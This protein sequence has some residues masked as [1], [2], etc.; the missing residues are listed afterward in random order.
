MT[1]GRSLLF[2]AASGA[3]LLAGVSG[4]TAGAFGIR[5][6]SASGLGQAFAGV[7]AGSAGLGSMFWNPATITMSPGWTSEYDATF[8]APEARIRPLPPTPTIGLGGSRDIGQSALVPASYS[9]Y[10]INDMLW[11]GMAST[12]PFGLIT[13]PNNVWAGQV[14][15]RSSKVYSLN[16]APTLGIKVNDWLSIGFGPTIEYF[17]TTLKSAA[18][19][20]PTAGSV[21]LKG[22]DVGAGFTAGATITPFAGTAFGVGYRSSVHHE[23]TGSLQTPAAFFPAKVSLNLPDQVTVGLSQAVLPNLKLNAGFEWTN[24]S[25]LKIP[26]VVSEATGAILG[27]VPLGYKDGFMYSFGGEYMLNPQWAIRLGAA[28]EVSPIDRSNRGTRVPD[29]DR[30]WASVG[31]S[32]KYNEKLQFD[33]GYSHIFAVGNRQIALQPG[34]PVFAPVGLP[35]FGVVEPSVNIFSVSGRYRWDDTRVAEAAPIIRKY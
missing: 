21:I 2:S 1:F 13:K 8:I 5:E 12:A 24:W 16:F 31:A 26:A 30:V 22:D 3:A 23:V 25:R 11:I 17:K 28:Y 6:Q 9:A 33:A 20:L 27:T 18:S 4:A 14:Y 10:Q 19:P 34:N 32:Y 15:S 35:F 29:T 7:A